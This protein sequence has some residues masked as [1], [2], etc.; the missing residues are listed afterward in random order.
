LQP[1]VAW[2]VQAFGSL[3][4]RA[5]SHCGLQARSPFRPRYARR[6]F[7]FQ[8]R[9]V[10]IL[11]STHSKRQDASSTILHLRLLVD[12][13]ILIVPNPRADRRTILVTPLMLD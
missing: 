8:R 6:G 9:S 13:T 2:I 3:D 11:Q 4:S 7:L 5:A 1:A 12:R 10:S